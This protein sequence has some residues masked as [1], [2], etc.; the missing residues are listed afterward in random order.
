VH[1]LHLLAEWELVHVVEGPATQSEQH[2]GNFG[3][4]LR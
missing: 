3:E 1:H 2:P 4:Q